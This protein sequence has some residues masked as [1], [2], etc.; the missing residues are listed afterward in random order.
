MA[1]GKTK[2]TTGD[3]MNSTSAP[4][5]LR[6][7]I[8]RW[9]RLDN[10]AKA[11][12]EDKKAVMDEAKGEGFDTKVIRKVIALR[13]LDKQKVSEEQAVLDLYLSAL[14]MDFDYDESDSNQDDGSE[15]S[16]V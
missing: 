1:K 2:E 6:K 13:K 14:G 12:T 11:I 7:I 9:E 16:M 4:E 8:E 10:D 3:G 15:D 5:K